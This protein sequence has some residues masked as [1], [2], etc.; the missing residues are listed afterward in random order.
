MIKFFQASFTVFLLLGMMAP[1]QADEATDQAEITKLIKACDAN[2]A[3]SCKDLGIAY[4]YGKNVSPDDVK[5]DAYYKR[6]VGLYEKACDIGSFEGC[7]RLGTAFL[8]GQSVDKNVPKAEELLN[9][10]CDG[11]YGIAC[12]I[13]GRMYY[14]GL[15]VEQNIPTALTKHKQGCEEYKNRTSCLFLG[16]IY[17][18]GRGVDK[19]IRVAVSYYKTSC[20]QGDKYSCNKVKDLEYNYN[21]N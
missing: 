6:A 8:T 15:G 19:D 21:L 10:S 18:R 16:K 3:K 13:L 9:F 4:K 2:D 1:L 17:E 11:G 5:A 7:A 12:S 20:S 14:N